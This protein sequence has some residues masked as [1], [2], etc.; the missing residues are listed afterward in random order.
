[1]LLSKMD[2]V[3][4]G[5]KLGC[6][7]II[8]RRTWLGLSQL[9]KGQKASILLPEGYYSEL[10]CF[11]RLFGFLSLYNT[12][13][14]AWTQLFNPFPVSKEDVLFLKHQDNAIYFSRGLY[15]DL[16]F[17]FVD[18]K[19]R[20]W[21][22]SHVDNTWSLVTE[23]NSRKRTASDDIP[24]PFCNSVA[25]SDLEFALIFACQLSW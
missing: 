13:L 3:L 5:G 1:M 14:L 9:C 17:R 2:S 15:T 22:S 21:F 12:L 19:S 11:I 10:K 25:L 23:A 8:Q 4:T 6:Q 16:S 24:F 7:F 18:F 20:I